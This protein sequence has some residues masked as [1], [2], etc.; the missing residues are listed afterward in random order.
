MKDK[1]IIV[2]DL[3]LVKAYRVDLTPQRT[4]RLQQLEQLVLDEA[5]SRLKDRVSDLAGRQGT[6][7][8]KS[9]SAPKAND[10]NLKLEAKRRLI[11]QIAGRITDLIQQ[12]AKNG[13]WLA[14]PKEINLQILNELSPAARE[15]IQKTVPCDFTKL[16]P[17]EVLEHFLERTAL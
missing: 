5:H 14:A 6:R 8:Q 12:N 3:G 17:A 7:T 2:V 10:Q 13:C 1:L 4:P 15:R 16:T 11:R 9:S